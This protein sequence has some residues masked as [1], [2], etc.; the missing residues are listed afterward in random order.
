MLRLAALLTAVV[1][2]GLLLDT[3]GA[4]A[5]HPLCT[6]ASVVDGDTFDCT[7]GMRVRL[8]QINAHTGTSLCK[9]PTRTGSMATM[10]GS[11]VR[12][13]AAKVEQEA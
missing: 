10:M 11:G 12:A 2:V 3:D 5:S 13:D 6:V 4:A 1:A 7:D 9:V 8:L